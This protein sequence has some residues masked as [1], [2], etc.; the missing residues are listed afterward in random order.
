MATGW[1]PGWSHCAY[2]DLKIAVLGRRGARV[3]LRTG[4]VDLA[5]AMVLELDRLLDEDSVPGHCWGMACRPIRGTTSTP[6]EHSYGVALDRNAPA[7]PLGTRNMSAR[8][9]DVCRSVARKYGFTWGGD[10]SRPDEM[11]FEFAGTPADAARLTRE[12]LP[13]GDLDPNPTK[14]VRVADVTKA[15][16]RELIQKAV[17]KEVREQTAALQARFDTLARFVQRVD[18]EVLSKLAP[19]GG[20]AIGEEVDLLRGAARDNRAALEVLAQALKVK[21]PA[22]TTKV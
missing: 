9:R 19:E 10:W 17:D 18:E 5:E 13:G 20:L 1:G 15:E 16:L 7:Y 4:V 11:H 8:E 12:L 22:P 2:G 21:L 6:S 14:G 3:S